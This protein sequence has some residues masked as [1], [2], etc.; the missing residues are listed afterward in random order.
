MGESISNGRS[1]MGEI[2]RNQKSKLF[3]NFSPE[4]RKCNDGVNFARNRRKKQKF[5]KNKIFGG[6]FQKCHLEAQDL[7]GRLARSGNQKSSPNLKNY[8]FFSKS[9]SIFQGHTVWIMA[10]F[11]AEIWRNKKIVGTI[12]FFGNYFFFR[13]KN[14]KIFFSKFFEMVFFA[15]PWHVWTGYIP[16]PIQKPSFLVIFNYFFTLAAN[17]K[18]SL[19]IF[20][21]FGRKMT[22]NQGALISS[23]VYLIQSCGSEL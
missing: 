2:G 8:Y 7:V 14:F 4:M 16:K 18:N 6:I 3:P 23:W 17:K 12:L 11:T 21:F 22:K 15:Y 19:V 5:P 20:N 1:I 10:D 13:K 9:G